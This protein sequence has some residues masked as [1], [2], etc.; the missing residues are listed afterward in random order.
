MKK[1]YVSGSI[2]LF[3][4]AVLFFQAQGLTVW[5]ETGPSEGFFP[6]VLSILLGVLSAI[7]LLQ[8]CSRPK[9]ETEPFRL[10]GAK[11]P[12]FFLYSGAFLAFAL[13]FFWM[14]YSLAVAVFLLFI[15]RFVE[16]QSWKTTVYVTVAS[17][18]GSYIIF[19]VFFTIPL[20]E[21]VLTPLM[22]RL[23]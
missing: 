13:I 23:R 2:L 14:G 6:L 17:I 8:A 1:D 20:P 4:A 7:I 18:I 12:K 9:G 10:F 11:R 22:Q 5:A 3:V 19:Q 21:G 16:Q 15:L